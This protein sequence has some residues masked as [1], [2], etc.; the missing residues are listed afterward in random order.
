MEDTTE[1]GKLLYDSE[2]EYCRNIWRKSSVELKEICNG[3]GNNLNYRL[4]SV[5]RWGEGVQSAKNKRHLFIE[6]NF[7]Y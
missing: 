6:Q 5:Q 7:F 3:D 2:T 1:E 4:N